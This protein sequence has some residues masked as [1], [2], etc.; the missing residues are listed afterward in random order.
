V[1]HAQVLA[2][3]TDEPGEHT[4][5]TV[6][7]IERG[8]EAAERQLPTG[9][10]VT[11]EQVLAAPDDLELNYRFAQTQIADGDLRG[12]MSTLER[13][14]L[15]RP[16]LARVRLLYA[17]VLFRLDNTDEAERELRTLQGM[18]MSPSLRA[19]LEQALR[20]IERRRRTTRYAAN[21]TFGV[22]GNT[23]R[24]AAPDSG[25]RIG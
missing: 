16:E 19:E 5:R 4:R 15:T 2:Q 13:I 25:K 20:E 3:N 10:R 18:E 12:A 23:N 1:A 17:I 14:L 22:Q 7:T 9:P 24:D 21:L 6:R 11:L 8:S